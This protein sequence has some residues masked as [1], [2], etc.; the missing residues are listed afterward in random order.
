MVDSVPIEDWLD[1]N[2]NPCR[3]VDS[4]QSELLEKNTNHA[5]W[6]KFEDEITDE[7][8]LCDRNIVAETVTISEYTSICNTVLVYPTIEN[9]S[10][11]DGFY[12]NHFNEY[13]KGRQFLII[14]DE[15]NVLDED[16]PS[17]NQPYDYDRRV[18]F[19]GYNRS[20]ASLEINELRVNVE[21]VG[22][23]NLLNEIKISG[24][25]IKNITTP[26]WPVASIGLKVLS[27][28]NC[29]FNENGRGDKH[30]DDEGNKRYFNK[31]GVK[32]SSIWTLADIY[33]YICEHYT[34]ITSELI[35]IGS[36]SGLSLIEYIGKFI[37]IDYRDIDNTD[38]A[39][40]TPYDFNIEGLG[41]LEAIIKVFEESKKYMMY[42]AY[43]AD[44]V[45]TITY[46]IKTALD[47]DRGAE[48][49]PILINIGELDTPP[50]ST[51]N[52]NSGDLVL[53]RETRNIGRVIV[54]GDFLKINT[55]ATTLAYEEF[56][57][58]FSADRDSYAPASGLDSFEDRIALALIDTKYPEKI[59]Q[60][61][62]AVP[63]NNMSL[64]IAGLGADLS[65]F[66]DEP[67]TKLVLT[68]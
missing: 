36:G 64:T 43:T 42:K 60:I 41:V 50:D 63:I 66:N 19:S 40:I 37:D 12:G 4:G 18:I 54:L 38:F 45:V 32:N 25:Y 52:F 13:V 14:T 47:A 26:S 8:Y 9:I 68:H 10:D 31:S 1:K 23:E 6:T 49:L 62:I 46:R 35:S 65:E 34:K 7:I 28:Q 3:N 16:L 24:C 11:Y 51:I 53:N 29:I 59:E 33:K 27:A 30:I 58:Q 39:L 44:G 48:D 2:G 57:G 5:V 61:Y 56:S 15:D 17:N 20:G 22:V 67:T 21:W 55:L